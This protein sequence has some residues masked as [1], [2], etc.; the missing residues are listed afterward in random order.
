MEVQHIVLFLSIPNWLFVHEFQNPL[1][2]SIWSKFIKLFEISL[3]ICPLEFF[4][5]VERWNNVSFN[6]PGSLF[7]CDFRFMDDS[8]NGLFIFWILVQVINTSSKV[9]FKN[10]HEIIII[11]FQIVWI[12]SNVESWCWIP[13]HPLTAHNISLFLSKFYIEHW[14]KSLESWPIPMK[15]GI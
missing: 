9:A 11:I 7:E 15:Q 14:E 2:F 13:T 12:G 3:T 8:S 6:T 1:V 4:I 10:S 5:G